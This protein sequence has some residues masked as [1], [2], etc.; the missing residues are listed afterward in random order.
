MFSFDSLEPT[1]HFLM[2]NGYGIKWPMSVNILKLY[3]K[4]KLKIESNFQN[5]GDT[6]LMSFSC[7]WIYISLKG[8]FLE[9]WSFS[10][11][12]KTSLTGQPVWRLGA[13]GNKQTIVPC[14]FSNSTNGSSLNLFQKSNWIRKWQSI[15]NNTV[16]IATNNIVL[17]SCMWKS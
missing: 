15:L 2:I 13:R 12:F 7:C 4:L 10:S 1:S 9:G 5:V 14:G 3:L 6:H 16:D 17:K 8:W 11:Y